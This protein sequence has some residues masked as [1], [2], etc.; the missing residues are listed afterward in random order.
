MK[1]PFSSKAHGF[2]LVEVIGVLAIIGILASM[3]APRVVEAIRAAKVD[4]SLKVY[5]SARQASTRYIKLNRTFPIDGLAPADPAYNRPYG[6]GAQGPLSASQTTFGDVLLHYGLLE[7]LVMS[8]GPHGANPYSNPS[9][10]PL[11]NGGNGHGVLT[12]PGL[13]YPMI[14]CSAYASNEETTRAFTSALFTTRVV[15]MLIPGLTPLEAGEV[16][17]RIDGP[18]KNEEVNGLADLVTRTVQAAP[19]DLLAIRLGDCR[20]T[21]GADPASPGTYDCWLYVAHD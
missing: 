13:N 17:T 1:R 6:D 4:A 5:Y 18:F 20:I 11:T 9:P 3:I 7:R 21:P 12:N 8:I 10:A 19:T 14:F 16:K 15:F 2:S